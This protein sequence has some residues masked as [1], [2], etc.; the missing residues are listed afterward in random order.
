MTEV[1]KDIGIIRLIFRTIQT[2]G[3]GSTFTKTSVFLQIKQIENW[4]EIFELFLGIYA[5]S[6]VRVGHTAKYLKPIKN[7]R[8]ENSVFYFLK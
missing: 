1:Q 6:P 4:H 7:A 8:I 5:V 2:F 3:M